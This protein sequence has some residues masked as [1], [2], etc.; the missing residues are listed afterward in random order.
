MLMYYFV[1]LAFV[2][3]VL[4]TSLTKKIWDLTANRCC[5]TQGEMM[6]VNFIILSFVFVRTIKNVVKTTNLSELD[7]AVLNFVC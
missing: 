3:C 5:R 7:C 1:V 6:Y 4:V 2:K